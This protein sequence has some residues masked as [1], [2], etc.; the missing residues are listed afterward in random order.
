MADQP[1]DLGLS[2]QRPRP[3]SELVDLQRFDADTA[4]AL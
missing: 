3:V 1:G 4:A 2:S